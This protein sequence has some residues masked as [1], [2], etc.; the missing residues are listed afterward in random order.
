MNSPG[1]EERLIAMA[2]DAGAED[3]AM[4]LSSSPMGEFEKHLVSKTV[5]A[6]V[7][8]ESVIIDTG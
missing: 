1:S 7:P 3:E 4:R 2:Y 8:P 6:R 5:M